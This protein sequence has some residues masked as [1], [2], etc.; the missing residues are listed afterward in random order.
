MIRGR[1]TLVVWTVLIVVRALGL[2]CARSRATVVV[3]SSEDQPCA[4][5]ILEYADERWKGKAILA[6]PLLNTTAFNL[7]ALFD[8]WGNKQAWEFLN[9]VKS[10]GVKTSSGNADSAI[11]VAS[12][13]AEFSLVDIDDG[14]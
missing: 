5:A 1:G 14:L 4:D 9:K 7:T 11:V 2:F 3:Y 6:N 10:L 13:Q 8:C 12:G